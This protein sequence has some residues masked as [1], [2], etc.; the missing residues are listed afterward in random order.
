M[1]GCCGE[2]DEALEADEEDEAGPEAGGGGGVGE[3]ECTVDAAMRVVSETL[4]V[5]KT[6]MVSDITG[7]PAAAQSSSCSAKETVSRVG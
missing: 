3:T 6:E 4:I 7:F 1:P 2:C 5:C